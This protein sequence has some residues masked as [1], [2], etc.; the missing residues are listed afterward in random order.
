VKKKEGEVMKYPWYC[1]FLSTVDFDDEGA[2][3]ICREPLLDQV[4]PQRAEAIID[5]LFEERGDW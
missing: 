2:L 1:K 5:Q 3:I 4:G